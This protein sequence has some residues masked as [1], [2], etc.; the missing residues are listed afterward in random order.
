[1]AVGEGQQESAEREREREV[2]TR[3]IT[4][5]NTLRTLLFA[6]TKFSEISDFP[7]FH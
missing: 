5:L 4:K 3:T 2:H 6:G 1:M 7:N